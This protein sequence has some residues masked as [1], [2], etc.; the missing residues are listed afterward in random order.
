MIAVAIIAVVVALAAGIAIG[1]WL[2]PN[3]RLPGRSRRTAPVRQILFPFTIFGISGRALEAAMRLARAENATLMPAY[4][5]T[6]PLH[7]AVDAPMPR[8]FGAAMP[9]LDVIEQRAAREG[10]AV[11][12]RVSR[13]RTVRDALRKLLEVEDFDRVVV[14]AAAQ[15]QSGFK[16]DDVAWL[17][18]HVPA[19]VVILRPGPE[20]RP[21]GPE[22]P[23]P[24]EPPSL[25]AP[26]PSDPAAPVPS[27]RRADFMPPLSR[28]ARR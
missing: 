19:E 3:G 13:G 28:L 6:V 26:Q 27:R 7:L 11:D 25:G 18:E 1:W 22:Q 12:S 8:Q 5:S 16:G 9:V 10:V 20:D 4:L 2:P 14:P 17:L 24:A 23:P 15:G 21:I